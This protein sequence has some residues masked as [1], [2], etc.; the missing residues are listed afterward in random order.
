MSRFAVCLVF[1]VLLAATAWAQHGG[2]LV[3]WPKP[4]RPEHAALEILYELAARE[5]SGEE[6]ARQADDLRQQWQDNLRERERMAESLAELAAGFEKQG[7]FVKALVLYEL[8]W[9]EFP[10]RQDLIGR[11]KREHA[12]A[13]LPIDLSTPDQAL[14]SLK[15]SLLTY[16]LTAPTFGITDLD[17]AVY[18]TLP[19]ERYEWRAWRE[20]LEAKVFEQVEAEMEEEQ[21]L[22]ALRTG[23]P[24]IPECFRSMIRDRLEDGVTV[25]FEDA[26]C[27]EAIAELSEL[28]G[29]PLVLTP[30]A[31]RMAA[32]APT[33][34]SLED[35]PLN[36]V[37]RYT[38]R[39][40]SLKYEVRDFSLLIEE[41]DEHPDERLLTLV[42]QHEPVEPFPDDA[43]PASWGWGAGLIDFMLSCAGLEEIPENWFVH[44]DDGL[45]LEVV[46]ASGG[47]V[48]N[49]CSMISTA[50]TGKYYGR[51]LPLLR[52][53][54]RYPLP[55][56][57]VDRHT[58]HPKKRYIFHVQLRRQ[59]QAMQALLDD[60][61]AIA[62]LLSSRLLGVD[63]RTP[64]RLVPRFD[65]N[66]GFSLASR[67][68]LLLDGEAYR[69]LVFDSEEDRARWLEGEDWFD[70]PSDL[71]DYEWPT[72]EEWEQELQRREKEGEEFERVVEDLGFGDLGR[73]THEQL[74]S[75]TEELDRRLQQEEPAKE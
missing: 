38:L 37:L 55:G 68:A 75:V 42:I 35:V 49:R 22:R 33:K 39:H 19:V 47:F 21:R 52:C 24:V 27:L 11:I 15:R 23:P 14:L 67:L 45:S 18:E 2:L 60:R 29:L 3:P 73:L 17:T 31:R 63:E 50:E 65:S 28:S 7:D 41:L 34:I 20:E 40:S 54:R 6:L 43:Q 62:R 25:R 48:G 32:H 64:G 59:V 8:M 71:D 26:S 61:E 12:L 74:E 44:V 4:I 13:N 10:G 51:V 16:K 5:V 46:T 1:H 30:E 9:K 66:D 58:G 56:E 53:L 36:F 72:E 70:M 57:W 69:F